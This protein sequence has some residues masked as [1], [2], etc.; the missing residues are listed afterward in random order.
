M[1]DLAGLEDVV[2]ACQNCD[3]CR[4]ADNRVFGSGSSSAPVMFIGEAPGREENV[5]GL[6]FIGDAGQLLDRALA[7][8][9]IPRGMCYV[10]TILKCWVPG[11]RKPDPTELAACVHYLE[12]QV[13]IVAPR[14][15]VALGAT[16]AQT[17][18]QI[19]SSIGK[20]RGSVMAGPHEVLVVPTWHPSYILRCGSARNGSKTRQKKAAKEFIADLKLAFELAEV[21]WEEAK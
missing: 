10:A 6:P 4:S 15:I 17:L 1:T 18:L 3:L 12:E 19:H 7:K 20:I 21:K 9:S 5:Q 16:T 11:N 13:R 8:I 14:V 2:G